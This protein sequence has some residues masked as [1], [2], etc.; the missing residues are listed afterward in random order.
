MKLN[1]LNLSDMAPRPHALALWSDP[2]SVASSGWQRST[3]L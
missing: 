1:V 2:P 3:K